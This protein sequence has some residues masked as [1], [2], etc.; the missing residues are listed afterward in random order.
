MVL[1]LDIPLDVGRKAADYIYHNDLT[2]EEYVKM[3]RF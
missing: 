3:E 2:L 1:F